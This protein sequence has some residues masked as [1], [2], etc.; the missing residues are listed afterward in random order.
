MLCGR[1]EKG[2][3]EEE[4]RKAGRWGWRGGVRD[5]RS[6]VNEKRGRHR[7]KREALQRPVAWIG[8]RQ[9][10]GPGAQSTVVADIN[11]GL[12]NRCTGHTGVA[13]LVLYS[14]KKEKRY[15]DQEAVKQ[16]KEDQEAV[17]EWSALKWTR[18]VRAHGTRWPGKEPY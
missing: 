3:Q 16:E 1:R 9:D 5:R 2:A 11:Q 13:R 14:I 15:E 18:L 6:K 17:A 12:T 10:A 7:T 4:R 8:C